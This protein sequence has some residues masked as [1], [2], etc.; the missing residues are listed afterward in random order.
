MSAIYRWLRE[1]LEEVRYEP[2]RAVLLFLRIIWVCVLAIYLWKLSPGALLWILAMVLAATGVPVELLI[3]R[4]VRQIEQLRR[5]HIC[6]TCGYDCRAT[7][8]RCPE[9]GSRLHPPSGLE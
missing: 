8:Q 4:R 5:D 6:L 1:W 2:D 7:P 9:C 3:R